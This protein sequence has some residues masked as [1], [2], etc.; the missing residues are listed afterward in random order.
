MSEQ[1]ACLQDSYDG[2]SIGQAVKVQR[3][4]LTGLTGVVIGWSDTG[5]CRIQLDVAQRG[6]LLVIDQTAVSESSV[7]VSN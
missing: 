3:G 2:L 5:R 6:V 4:S 1:L 7:A